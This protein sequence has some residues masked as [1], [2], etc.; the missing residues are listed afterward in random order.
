MAVVKSG[1]CSRVFED[2]FAVRL[3]Y[4]DG[5]APANDGIIDLSIHDVSDS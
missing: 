3:A 1:I 4:A 5:I 2:I